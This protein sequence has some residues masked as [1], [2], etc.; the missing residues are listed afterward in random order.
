M[1]PIQACFGGRSG[2]RWLICG[3]VG[4]KDIRV[5]FDNVSRVHICFYGRL[6]LQPT[7]ARIAVPT[8]PGVCRTAESV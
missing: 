8:Q 1:Q 4:L 7:V 5:N 6:K 3:F 2:M